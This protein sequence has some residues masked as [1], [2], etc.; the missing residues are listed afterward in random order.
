[1]DGKRDETKGIEAT[2]TG[3]GT[4]AAVSEPERKETAGNHAKSLAYGP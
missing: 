2:L 3:F 4:R 1:M